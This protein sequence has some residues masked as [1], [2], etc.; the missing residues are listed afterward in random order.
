LPKKEAVTREE[1]ALEPFKKA[2]AVFEFL[3]PALPLT[4]PLCR[5]KQNEEFWNCIVAASQL[6][7]QLGADDADCVGRAGAT[8]FD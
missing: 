1:M 7:T 3:S 4:S 5:S 6:G 8:F 2:T